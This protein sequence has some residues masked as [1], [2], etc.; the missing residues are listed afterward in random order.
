MAPDLLGLPLVGGLI[1]CLLNC[2]R[3]TRLRA[4]ANGW[5]AVETNRNYLRCVGECLWPWD[6]PQRDPTGNDD[7]GED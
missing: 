5:D 1:F 4:E 3:E 2:A 6:V 7:H